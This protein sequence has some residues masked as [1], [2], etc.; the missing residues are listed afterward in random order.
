MHAN[1][2]P[3]AGFKRQV[4]IRIGAED[5]PLLEAAAAEHGSLQ[6]ALLAGLHALQAP[7]TDSKSTVKE[8]E[9]TERSTP[10][11]RTTPPSASEADPAEEIHSGEAAKLLGLKTSTVSS[12]IRSGRLPGRYDAEPTWLGW[13]T[14]R[15]A[16]GE[17]LRR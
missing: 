3:P 6:A 7:S 8:N 14:T 16:V 13:M 1:T 4:V 2:Q 11:K 12:Y 9:T 15:G 5:W 17:Y 10:R